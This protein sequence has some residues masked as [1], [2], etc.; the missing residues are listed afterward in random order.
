MALFQQEDHCYK[1]IRVGNCWNNNYIEYESNGDKNKNLSVKEYL[2]EIKPYLR[3]AIIDLPKSGTW[4]V[5]LT[6]ANNFIS[7]KDDDEEQV[8]HSKSNN[9]EFM[10]YD[11]A[12]D[13]VDELL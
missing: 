5:Q 10:P 1:P 2:N 13:I 12:N 3:D 7:P 8:M 4:K 11:N 9:I 6:I